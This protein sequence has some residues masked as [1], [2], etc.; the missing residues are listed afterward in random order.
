M[1]KK[2]AKEFLKKRLIEGDHWRYLHHCKRQRKVLYSDSRRTPMS[3]SPMCSCQQRNAWPSLVL[4]T[5]SDEVVL[6]GRNRKR[7]PDPVR[8]RSVLLACF[9]ADKKMLKLRHCSKVD[10]VNTNSLVYKKRNDSA[11]TDF[12]LQNEEECMYFITLDSIDVHNSEGILQS[13]NGSCSD[14]KIMLTD[15]REHTVAEQCLP[16]GV[17]G[18]WVRI[19][20]EK[21][22]YTLNISLW[23]SLSECNSKQFLCKS[24]KR[25]HFDD[26]DMM[27][28]G[29]LAV[30]LLNTGSEKK[31]K[32]RKQK[33]RPSFLQNKLIGKDFNGVD[34][35]P[36]FCSKERYLQ[37]STCLRECVENGNFELF[38]EMFSKFAD[39]LSNDERNDIE[40]KQFLNCER[41]QLNAVKGD[42]R[43]AKKL[44]QEVVDNV[45]SKSPNKVFILN[46][47]YLLLANTHL[48][49]GNYGTAEECLNVL[50]RDKKN[51]I[52]YEDVGYFY[53]IYGIVGMNFGKKL[54]RMSKSLLKESE[55]LLKLALNNLE[56]HPSVF[57]LLCKAHLNMAQLQ[58]SKFKVGLTEDLKEAESSIKAVENFGIHKL[59]KHVQCL[60]AVVKA[61][62]FFAEMKHQDGDL[63]LQQAKDQA[64]ASNFY[65]E[66]SMCEC[67]QEVRNGNARNEC[68]NCN[69]RNECLACFTNQNCSEQNNNET[70]SSVEYFAD[71]SFS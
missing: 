24:R 47:A 1:W 12:D 49:E 37:V 17:S 8:D 26:E 51:G 62:L 19:L 18:Y 40:L 5:K 27:K 65:E 67:L 69:V 61:E 20:G 50:Q 57:N 52:P 38:E 4:L 2:N 59:S 48:I 16:E 60:L 15:V 9:D 42:F 33:K 6:N 56:K 14:R 71:Q 53:L 46:R 34:H 45:I 31:I 3:I 23:Q 70:F 13:I 55:E 36:T 68:R 29:E 54:P 28:I 21:V 10:T 66:K 11:L 44:L 25:K 7:F 35:T 22:K 63:F 43:E 41:S 64:T 30:D 32:R 39:G 58:I